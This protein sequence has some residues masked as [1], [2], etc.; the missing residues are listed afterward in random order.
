[1]T[2]TGDNRV[3]VTHQKVM[4]WKMTNP[5]EA[6]GVLGAI[7]PLARELAGVVLLCKLASVSTESEY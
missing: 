7:Q 6:N 5:K 4:P 2:G 3:R 1:M